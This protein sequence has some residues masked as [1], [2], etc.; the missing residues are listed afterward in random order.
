MA[1]AHGAGGHPPDPA[2][3]VDP[4]LED[5]SVIFAP[6]LTQ[7]AFRRF[8]RGF[9]SVSA[10]QQAQLGALPSLQAKVSAVF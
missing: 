2:L 6:E 8:A 1:L 5:C 4:S 7:A 9:G 10:F 3:H